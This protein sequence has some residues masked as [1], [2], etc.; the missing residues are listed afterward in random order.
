M[1][2]SRDPRFLPADP[3]GPASGALA[4]AGEGRPVITRRTFLRRSATGLVGTLAACDAIPTDPA[5][6]ESGPDVT[7]EGV[8]ASLPEFNIRTFGAL[9][10][11]EADDTRAI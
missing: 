10:D 4:P 6:G 11:G 7:V 5:Q 3:S 1:Q 8:G 9:G 2:F